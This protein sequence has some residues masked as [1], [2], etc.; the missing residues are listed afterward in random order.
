MTERIIPNRCISMG[1]T[2]V[3]VAL[4]W[5]KNLRESF[6]KA[7]QCPGSRNTSTKECF[8]ILK[9]HIFFL[10]WSIHKIKIMLEV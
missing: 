10:L 2:V 9:S 8:T 3:N 6:V 7:S 1:R 4:G 5:E